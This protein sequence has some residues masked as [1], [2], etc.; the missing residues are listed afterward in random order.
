MC[1]LSTSSINLQLTHSLPITSFHSIM[2][3]VTHILR[4]LSTSSIKIKLTH[5]LPIP[6]FYSITSCITHILR[7]LYLSSITIHNLLT[8]CLYHLLFNNVILYSNLA[9]T[10]HLFKPDIAYSQ[11]AH[12]LLLFNNVIP[13]TP[14]HIPSIHSMFF[15]LLYHLQTSPCPTPV[16]LGITRCAMSTQWPSQL[17]ITSYPSQHKKGSIIN[18]HNIGEWG[19]LFYILLPL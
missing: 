12:Y 7:R 13:H 11:L 16:P 8:P 1:A 10:I 18:E 2:S 3:C 17:A 9:Y 4:T 5:S 19:K 15:L 14:L 6:S